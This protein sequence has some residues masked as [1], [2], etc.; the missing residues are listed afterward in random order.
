MSQC[1]KC[2]ASV[3]GSVYRNTLCPSCGAEL[4][5]CANCRHY[6]KGQ[7][8]DCR[9]SIQEPVNDKNRANFCDFFQINTKTGSPGER[10]D[11]E[12]SKDAINALFGE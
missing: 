9:E 2:G 5:S 4:H 8:Y 3:E 7:P 1:V 6:A 11:S 12:S 10:S